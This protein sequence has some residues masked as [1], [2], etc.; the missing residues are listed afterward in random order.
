MKIIIDIYGG[1]NAP[2]APL[3]GAAMAVK[4]LGVEIIAVGN[5]AEMKEICEKEKIK[6][7]SRNNI[8]YTNKFSSIKKSLTKLNQ[9]S[10]IVDGE[11][12][13]FDEQGKSDFGLLQ[14]SIKEKKENFTYVVFDLIALNGEDLRTLPLI[15]RKKKLELLLAKAEN[16][17]MFST[18]LINKGEECFKFAKENELEGIIAKNINSKYKEKRTEDWLKIKCYL[19]QEFVIIGY[20]TSE[21]NKILSAIIL[22]YYN[23]DE[24]IYVGKVSTGFTETDK[25]DLIK[26]FKKYIIKTCPIKEKIKEENVVWLSPKLVCEIQYAELTKDKLLRQPSFITLRAD[27]D[28]KQVTLEVKNAKQ[29]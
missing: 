26:T 25:K 5:E 21:K 13:V 11:I 15:D 27:K 28:A 7:L 9:N 16:N 14:K 6:M 1:D 12:V 19:R 22:G 4:D 17:L 29:N 23:K 20:T 3:K 24:L 2:L 10:F 18:H 8:D